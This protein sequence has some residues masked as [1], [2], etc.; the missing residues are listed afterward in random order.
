MKREVTSILTCS[1]CDAEIARA[2]TWREP[3]DPWPHPFRERRGEKCKRC[4]K[5][6]KTPSTS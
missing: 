4:D 1:Q 3:G 5:L 2:K 6:D